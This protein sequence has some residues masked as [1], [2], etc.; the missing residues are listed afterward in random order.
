MSGKKKG[1]TPEDIMTMAR[2]LVRYANCKPKI[3]MQRL[4]EVELIR[5][6]YK[7][8]SV[9]N[10]CTGTRR[11]IK[12]GVVGSGMTEEMAD[13]VRKVLNEQAAAKNE[14]SQALPQESPTEVLVRLKKNYDETYAK[15]DDIVAKL[16]DEKD[17]KME[18]YDNAIHLVRQQQQALGMAFQKMCSEL[19]E[20]EARGLLWQK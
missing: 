9:Y 11:L 1:I 13:A 10:F 19:M 8:A 6:N 5:N 3:A 4:M 14:P 2:Y 17:A 7:K 18:E 15:Y 12:D 16:Q 20:V